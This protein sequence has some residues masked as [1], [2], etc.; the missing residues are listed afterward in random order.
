MAGTLIV[1]RWSMRPVKV[2]N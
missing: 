1:Y 2:K